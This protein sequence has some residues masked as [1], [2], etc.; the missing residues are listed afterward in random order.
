MAQDPYGFDD[1]APAGTP[2]GDASR[3]LWFSVS[4]ALLTSVG[5]CACYVPYFVAAPLGAY[6]AYLGSRALPLARD[7]STR[8]MATA[9]VVA[10]AVSS[11]VSG[12]FALVILMY[13]AFLVIY[14]AIIFVA[15]FAGIASESGGM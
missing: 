5:M 6:G 2:T 3:A 8:T 1:A 10:G 12:M 11:V 13:V 14:L 15:V 9:G 7:D 4:A